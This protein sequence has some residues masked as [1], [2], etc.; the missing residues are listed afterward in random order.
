VSDILLEFLQL[1]NTSNST[2]VETEKHASETRG[3]S[4]GKGTPSIN[5]RRVGL[6]GVILDDRSDDPRTGADFA[7]H[8]CGGWNRSMLVF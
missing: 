7:A 8:D 6:D 5:L 3:A 2:D 4:H 1:K